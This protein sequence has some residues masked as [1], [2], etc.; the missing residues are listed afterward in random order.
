MVFGFISAIG[1]AISSGFS[2]VC[3]TVSSIGSALSSFAASVGSI[4][5]SAAETVAKVIETLGVAFGIIQPNEKIDDL[6]DRALQAAEAGIHPE[7]FNTYNEYMAEIRAFEVNPEKSNQYSIET[8]QLAG[9]GVTCK[10]IEE[11]FEL[12]QGVAGQMAAMVALNPSFFTAN[13]LENW[14]HSET[15]INKIIDYFDNK[16]GA[17][18]TFK[19]EQQLIATE[20]QQNNKSESLIESELEQAKADL[21]QAAMAATTH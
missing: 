19:V 3:S 9:V 7:N 11:K 10:A 4:I 1:G 13:R 18:D 15:D 12:R 20:K 14:F 17:S 6:G 5:L 8:K 16:L 2:A 21:Q